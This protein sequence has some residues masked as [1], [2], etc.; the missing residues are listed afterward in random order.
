[1][2]AAI[3]AILPL[4]SLGLAAVLSR[5]RIGGGIGAIGAIGAGLSGQSGSDCRTWTNGCAEPTCPQHQVY[6]RGYCVD[7]SAPQISC[8]IGQMYDTVNRK[9]VPIPAG[10]PGSTIVSTPTLRSGGKP[11]MLILPA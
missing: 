3:L 6:V 11:I 5:R 2:K 8:V 4:S 7:S 10:R 9:C 1:M